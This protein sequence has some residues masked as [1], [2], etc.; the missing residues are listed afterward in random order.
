MLGLRTSKTTNLAVVKSFLAHLRP[1]F[2]NKK[3]SWSNEKLPSCTPVLCDTE[4]LF[5]NQIKSS[6]ALHFLFLYLNMKY[7]HE[8]NAC[9]QMFSKEVKLFATPLAHHRCCFTAAASPLVHH[10]LC[11]I[12]GASSLVHHLWCITSGASPLVHHLWCITYGASTSVMH[13]WFTHHHHI[14]YPWVISFSKI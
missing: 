6:M 4:V 11:I 14:W 3:S 12:A 8:H 2:Q 7:S 9:R 5:W 10:L 13:H 1:D